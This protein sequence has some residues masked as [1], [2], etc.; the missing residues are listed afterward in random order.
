MPTF[1]ITTKKVAIQV[2][3]EDV[4]LMESRW[5]YGQYVSRVCYRG[6]KR[7][8]E[9]L[10]VLVAVRAFG[11]IPLGMEVDHINRDRKDNRRTNLR[12]VTHVVN[13]GN[14]PKMK[15]RKGHV[16]TSKYKGV[17]LPR[18]RKK[19]VAYITIDRKRVCLGRYPTEEEAAEAYRRKRKELDPLAPP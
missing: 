1:L 14:L 7:T 12:V 10:H 3:D 4:D 5:G 15:A 17:T 2:S 11:P 9:Y 19:W 8:T 18:G 16:L 6:D 13:Q